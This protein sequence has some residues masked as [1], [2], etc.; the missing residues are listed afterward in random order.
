MSINVGSNFLYQGTKFL[1]DRQNKINS[2]EDLK[3]WEIPIPDG[4]EVYVDNS[5]YIFNSTNTFD[6]ITG[7]FRKRTTDISQEFGTGTDK[8][9]SQAVITERFNELD[10]RLSK[11]FASVFPLEFK[12]ITGGG[13]FE[14]GNKVK[15]NI[16][17]TI[18]IKGESEILSPDTVTVNSMT[19]G[20]TNNTSYVSSTAIEQNIPGSVEFRVVATYGGLSVSKS[21]NYNFYY[22]KYFGT[23]EKTELN[24]SDVLSFS[25]EFIVGNSYS[26]PT[27]T[28]DCTGEKY[29]YYVIPRAV[30]KDSIEFWVDGLKNTDLVTRD[31]TV[32]TDT[33]LEIDYITI[34]LNNKQNGK[35]SIEIK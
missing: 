35:L 20:I 14:V 9:I 6:D 11:L 30:F 33:G 25:K 27:T 7:K 15:P 32:T 17:W 26:M 31:I 2:L 21:V 19:S 28:F 16:S 8:V 29:P 12:S 34:R 5:W 18:G 1:D 3:T 13:S 10:N 24:N 22:R 23:S 4:F